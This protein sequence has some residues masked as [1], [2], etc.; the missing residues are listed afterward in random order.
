M[1]FGGLR[2]WIHKHFWPP[3]KLLGPKRVINPGGICPVGCGKVKYLESRL[4]GEEAWRDHVSGRG[5]A[6]DPSTGYS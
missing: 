1:R 6:H 2:F 3:C 5:A 4:Y